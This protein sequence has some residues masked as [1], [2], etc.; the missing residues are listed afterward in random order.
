MTSAKDWSKSPRPRASTLLA[1]AGIDPHLVSTEEISGDGY[2]EF[3]LDADGKRILNPLTL[4]MQKRFAKWPSKKFG[5]RV[6]KA[7]AED[8]KALALGRR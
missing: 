7:L 5:A 2:M 1:G 6:L 4:G 3:V 8:E